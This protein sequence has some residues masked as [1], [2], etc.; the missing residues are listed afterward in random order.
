MDRPHRRIFQCDV[1]EEVFVAQASLLRHQREWPARLDGPTGSSRPAL[2]LELGAGLAKL[3]HEAEGVVLHNCLINLR[4]VLQQST[5]ITIPAVR[6]TTSADLAPDQWC[7]RF[8]RRRLILERFA[9]E[10]MARTAR[11]QLCSS[12]YG[13]SLICGRMQAE[14]PVFFWRFLTRADLR[15]TLAE[16]EI[17]DPDLAQA[18]LLLLDQE[19]LLKLLR[20]LLKERFSLNRLSA[21]LEVLLEERELGR[22]MTPQQLVTPAVL[23]VMLEP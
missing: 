9:A 15:D 14:L 5:G 16:L 13:S 17:S 6:V 21:L 18:A 10:Q 19:L 4:A 11:E 8:R 23:A 20:L 3:D 22:P 1:C 12:Y 2:E 7:L